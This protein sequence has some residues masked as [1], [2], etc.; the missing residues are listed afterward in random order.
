VVVRVSGLEQESY[1]ANEQERFQGRQRV[2]A[3]SSQAPTEDST[4]LQLV[5]F[6]TIA[7][8][9]SGEIS[10]VVISG[11]AFPLAQLSTKARF[12]HN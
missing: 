4:P 8:T 9:F 3:R 11:L 10:N 12:W 7:T 1:I 6:E 2:K 5:K